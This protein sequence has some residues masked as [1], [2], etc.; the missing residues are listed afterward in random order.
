MTTEATRVQKALDEVAHDKIIQA[1]VDLLMGQGFFGQLAVRLKITQADEWCPTMAV[2]GHRMYYS[3]EFVK[4][5][6]EEELKFV[7]GHEIMHCVYQHFLRIDGRDPRL[8]NCAGDYVINWELKECGIGRMPIASKM[9]NWEEDR[10]FYAKMGIGP[11]DPG[12]LI[13]AKY[14]GMTTEEVYDLLVEDAKNGGKHSD[15]NVKNW[16]VHLDPKGGDAGEGAGEDEGEGAGE[17]ASGPV[18]MSQE[19][20]DQLSDELKKA[21][22]DAAKTADSMGKGAGNI[23]GG[24]RRLIKEWTESKIVWNEYLERRILSTQKSDYTWSRSSRKGRDQGIYLPGMDNEER[25][26]LHIAVDT[27][28]STYMDLPTFLGEIRGI[29]E[30]F[31]D[32]K[33]TIWCFD[34]KTYTVHEFTPDNVYD[35]DDFQ[36][37]GLGGTDFACNWKMMKEAGMIPE[38]FLMFTD[39]EPFGSYGD[40]WY[41]DTIFLV[42]GNPGKEAPFGVTLHYEN[43]SK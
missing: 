32:F 29:M 16:D 10:E 19:E 5:M 43:I 3:S 14:K 34:T 30:Q 12:G 6:D 13:D 9:P 31:S 1:R 27:S 21:V 36:I 17:G 4:A 11:N 23:P 8:W 39:L 33:V 25:I 22:I 37:E 26:E 15:E 2:D 18:K 20:L 41:C 35:M 42:R 28:G 24:V 7:V 40:P 38:T